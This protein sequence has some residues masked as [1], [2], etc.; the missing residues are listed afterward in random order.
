MSVRENSQRRQEGHE[1]E[2]KVG[3]M[4]YYSQNGIDLWI[5]QR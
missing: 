1:R 4:G 2:C 5:T 3:F